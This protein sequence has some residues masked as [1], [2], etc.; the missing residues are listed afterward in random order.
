[1]ENM[2]S[3]VAERPS[4]KT[5]WTGDGKNLALGILNPLARGYLCIPATEVPS[6]RVWSSA[7]F[8]YNDTNA[9]MTNANVCKRVRIRDTVLGLK[10]SNDIKTFAA[11]IVQG[12]ADDANPM[13]TDS[14]TE[15]TVVE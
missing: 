4:F 3:N 7:G 5:F 15:T 2:P 12:M 14:V 13:E 1:M 6:E 11:A 8:L 9:Q 10:T